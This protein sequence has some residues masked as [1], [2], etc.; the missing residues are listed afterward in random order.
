[1]DEYLVS[2]K[3]LEKRLRL[4]RHEMEVAQKLESKLAVA[5]RQLKTAQTDIKKLTKE[6]TKEKNDVENLEKLSIT[7]IIAEIKGN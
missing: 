1:M 3:D 4:T 5:R 2:R 6:L 7:R